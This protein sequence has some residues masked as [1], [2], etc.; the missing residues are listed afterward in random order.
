[1]GRRPTNVSGTVALAGRGLSKRFGHIRALQDVDIDTRRG[2][3]LGVVGDNGAGKSTLIQILTGVLRPDAGYLELDGK[4]ATFRSPRDARRAGVAAVYQDMALVECLD[5]ATNV[6]L[7]DLPRRGPFVS[8][9]RMESETAAIIG[10][11]MVDGRSSRTPV[12]MLAAGQRQIIAVARAMRLD[13]SIVV[14]DEPTAAL[15][16]TEKGRITGIIDDLRAQ[17]RAIVLVSHDLELVL[18]H[19]DRIQVMR[20]GRTAAVREREA[21]DRDEIISLIT[22]ASPGVLA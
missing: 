2:E 18:G 20:H 7:G 3:V 12:G 19:A 14:L 11:L 5:M 8:R 6:F 10:G 9:G 1:M 22:G 13:A 21:T 17:A 15:G 4:P 16:V